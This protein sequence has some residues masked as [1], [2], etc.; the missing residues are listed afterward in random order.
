MQDRFYAAHRFSNYG[1][2]GEA[3]KHLLQDYQKQA[4]LNENISSVEDMQNFMERYP[5][6][7]SQSH[8]V[9]KHVALMSELSRL[10]E[11][12]WTRLVARRRRCAQCLWCRFVI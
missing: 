11:V 12:R 8:N 9:S 6:F 7:R 5:I 1:D 2:L 4:K 10:I 3:I